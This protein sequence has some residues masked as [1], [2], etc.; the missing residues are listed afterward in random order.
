MVAG[1]MLVCG[2]IGRILTFARMMNRPTTKRIL[3]TIMWVILN[4]TLYLAMMAVDKN[5]GPHLAFVALRVALV[6]SVVMMVLVGV[7]LVKLAR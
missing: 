6:T 1:K 5:N 7:G 4:L 2:E 3:L